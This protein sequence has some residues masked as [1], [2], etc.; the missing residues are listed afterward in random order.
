MGG[1]G[2][3]GQRLGGQRPGRE[4]KATICPYLRR[5]DDISDVASSVAS[6]AAA[7]SINIERECMASALHFTPS[8]VHQSSCC[9]NAAS[10]VHCPYYVE[11]SGGAHRQPHVAK[12]Q[13][14]R[15]V[16]VWQQ[17]RRLLP[18]ARGENKRRRRIY[19]I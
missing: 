12:R 7:P 14:A 5:D 10:Y 3:G 2:L 6:N 15:A 19:F 1:Q 8:S 4:F 18:F 13:P 16:G 17:V 9:M 11:A